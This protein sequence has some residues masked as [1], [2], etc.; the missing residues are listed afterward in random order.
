MGIISLLLMGVLM[1]K[2]GP[3]QGRSDCP[4]WR[5]GE[6]AAS[7]C[8]RFR[9]QVTSRVASSKPRPLQGWPEHAYVMWDYEDLAISVHRGTSLHGHCSW[10]LRLLSGLASAPILPLPTLA[11]FPKV[12]AGTS[13]NILHAELC[14]SLLPGD[15]DPAGCLLAAAPQGRGRD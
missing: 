7:I 15:S 11:S 9:D 6:R 2:P 10:R 5:H 1:C 14:Q 4:R 13:A 8:P 12:E 3:L